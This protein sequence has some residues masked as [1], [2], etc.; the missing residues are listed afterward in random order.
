MIKNFLFALAFTSLAA[1]APCYGWILDRDNTLVAIDVSASTIE[2]QVARSMR[3]VVGRGA[4]GQATQVCPGVFL[5]TAHGVFDREDGSSRSPFR[6]ILEKEPAFA[7]YP[8]SV[9]TISRL[10]DRW[11][12]LSPHEG[13]YHDAR[14]QNEDY[15]FLGV[16]S[17]AK[18]TDFVLPLNVTADDILRLSKKDDRFD[19]LSFRPA[20][21]FPLDTNGLPKLDDPNF[22]GLTLESM[23]EIYSQPYVVQGACR[24]LEIPPQSF[25][26]QDKHEKERNAWLHDCPAE[27]GVSGSPMILIWDRAPY[28]V[29]MTVA[30]G[31][32]HFDT[33]TA[34]NATVSIPMS[35]LC[36]DYETICSRTCPTLRDVGI[37]PD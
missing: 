8:L 6:S 17:N 30:A 31:T 21:Q 3:T 23:T 22:V 16:P 25:Y 10:D 15:V 19:F 13:A 24:S 14:P 37:S 2:A 5:T 4:G 33:S 11:Q 1:G 12:V 36:S 32:G 28:L 26:L 20:S 34:D 9:D 27:K 7:P 35:E 18:D 29:G